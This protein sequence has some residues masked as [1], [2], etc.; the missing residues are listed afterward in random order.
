MPNSFIVSKFLS[1]LDIIQAVLYNTTS[2]PEIAKVRTS[3]QDSL[4]QLPWKLAIRIQNSFSTTHPKFWVIPDFIGVNLYCAVYIHGVFLKS[5]LRVLQKSR[6]TEIRMLCLEGEQWD[7][8]PW[9]NCL[10]SRMERLQSCCPW[11]SLESEESSRQ[12]PGSQK[13]KAKCQWCSSH[14]EGKSNLLYLL[15]NFLYPS[16]LAPE[17]YLEYIKFCEDLSNS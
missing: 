9:L 15:Y 4:Q 16:W 10:W 11:V 14:T 13:W 2:L 12:S 7:G 1:C 8:F 17:N 3:V 5:L 6:Q